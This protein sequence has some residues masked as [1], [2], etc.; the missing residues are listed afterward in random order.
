[1]G[2]LFLVCL[3]YLLF[4]TGSVVD[5]LL[6]LLVVVRDLPAIV[7]GPRDRA[8]LERLGFSRVVMLDRALFVVA[9]RF[10][11]GDVVQVLTDLDREGRKL[12]GLLGKELSRRGVRV[13]ARLREA[14]FRT[15]L[16]HIE[17]LDSYLSRLRSE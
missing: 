17:G 5:E 10:E 14:L 2:L 3:I 1:M 8:A 13:D 4:F 11:R 12:Y 16:S 9:E 7:E 6:D 15:N